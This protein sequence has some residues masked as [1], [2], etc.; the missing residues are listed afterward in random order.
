[1]CETCPH[2]GGNPEI[3]NPTGHCDHL[4]YPENCLICQ[5]IDDCRVK[6]VQ[7]NLLNKVAL[8]RSMDKD[9]VVLEKCPDRKW[10]KKERKEDIE[11]WHPDRELED[12]ETELAY[13]AGAFR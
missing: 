4:Y 10:K 5:I 13:Y 11:D 6:A 3:R 12:W 9:M 2:C 7:S 8:H 1:M